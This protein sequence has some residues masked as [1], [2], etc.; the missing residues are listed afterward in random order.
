MVNIS[1]PN[2]P[3]DLDDCIDRL[4]SR[5]DELAK[6]GETAQKEAMEARMKETE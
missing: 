2:L 1:P 6:E 3:Q 4:T 5:Q